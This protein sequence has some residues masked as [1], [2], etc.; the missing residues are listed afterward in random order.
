MGS[1]PGVGG[2]WEG[3]KQRVQVAQE[4]YA[5]ALHEHVSSQVVV[6]S[7]FSLRIATNTTHGSLNRGSQ[8]KYKALYQPIST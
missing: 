1:R 6:C 5:L 7:R 3:Q 8:G 4:S 2:G